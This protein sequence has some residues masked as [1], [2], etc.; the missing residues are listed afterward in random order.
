MM[1]V[2]DLPSHKKSDDDGWFCTRPLFDPITK[3]LDWVDNLRP[4]N[5]ETSSI[6]QY[7][8]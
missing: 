1:N 6:K 8:E 4:P 2:Q 7:Y 3:L 5:V